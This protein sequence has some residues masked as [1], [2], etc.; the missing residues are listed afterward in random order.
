MNTINIIQ[1]KKKR[2]ESKNSVK[3]NVKGKINENI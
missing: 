2:D 3:K 1:Q